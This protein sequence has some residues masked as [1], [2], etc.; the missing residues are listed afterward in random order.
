[1][2]YILIFGETKEEHDRA[3]KDV[4]NRL[5]K[6]GLKSNEDK[7]VYCH[8]DVEFLTFNISFNKITPTQKQS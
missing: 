6:Y 5:K 2:D 7:C 1:M 4:M 3:L 8:D